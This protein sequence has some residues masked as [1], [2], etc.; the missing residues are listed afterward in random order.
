MAGLYFFFKPTLLCSLLSSA[1]FFSA[2][3]LHVPLFVDVVARSKRVC[4]Y[5]FSR[6]RFFLPLCGGVFCRFLRYLYEDDVVV[7]IGH[8]LVVVVGCGSCNWQE[9]VTDRALENRQ[10][11]YPTF[12]GLRCLILPFLN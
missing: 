9:Q 6:W 4:Q 10:K 5:I 12:F 1:L 11:N 8:K 7:V 3:P 2:L